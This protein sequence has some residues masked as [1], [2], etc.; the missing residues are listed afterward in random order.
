[1][2]FWFYLSNVASPIIL[3]ACNISLLHKLFMVTLSSYLKGKLQLY[4]PTTDIRL[5]KKSSEHT[6]QRIIL[7]FLKKN[8]WVSVNWFNTN[9]SSFP[10]QYHCCIMTSFLLC[11]FT[12]I[13]FFFYI[14]IP[15]NKSLKYEFLFKIFRDISFHL[16][17]YFGISECNRFLSFRMLT[18]F[19]IAW[20]MQTH[21]HTYRF[22]H[23]LTIRHSI[24]RKRTVFMKLYHLLYQQQPTTTKA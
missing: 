18:P 20:H 10:M 6:D 7:S 24:E 4:T 5:E 8:S 2:W 22:G 23:M 13:C 1:M 9:I 16:H 12:R 19:N 17:S 21:S 15:C 11:S 3:M 14:E